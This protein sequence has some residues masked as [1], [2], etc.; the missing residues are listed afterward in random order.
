MTFSVSLVYNYVVRTGNHKYILCTDFSYAITVDQQ[1]HYFWYHMIG[2]L[3]N[4]NARSSS[5]YKISQKPQWKIKVFVLS[6]PKSWLRTTSSFSSAQTHSLSLLNS[7]NWSWR[8]LLARPVLHTNKYLRFLILQKFLKRC[9]FAWSFELTKARKPS[10]QGAPPDPFTR[11][12]PLELAG[13]SASLRPRFAFCAHHLL[14]TLWLEAPTENFWHWHWRTRG[15][16]CTTL[17]TSTHS[18]VAL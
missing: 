15:Y 4:E 12:L 6:Q 5:N 3:L 11:A 13:G 14:Q 17:P 2:I 18:T 8:L 9:K 7:V 1:G 16:A 10:L